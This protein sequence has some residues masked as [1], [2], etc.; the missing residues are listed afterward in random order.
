M[1]CTL[2]LA[3]QR[4]PQLGAVQRPCVLLA[5]THIPV[6]A[7]QH[8]ALPDALVASALFARLLTDGASRCG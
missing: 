1:L 7:G 3:R 4:F 2:R 8:R 5:H 6:L